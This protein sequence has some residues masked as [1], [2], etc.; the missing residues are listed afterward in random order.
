MA[1][2]KLL[3]NKKII[4]ATGK[5]EF[6]K[7]RKVKAEYPM[8]YL[9]MD[10]ESKSINYCKQVQFLCDG[11]TVPIYEL[12]IIKPRSNEE[13]RMFEKGVFGYFTDGK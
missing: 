6:V 8:Q 3:L 11:G 4:Q 2:E 9:P 1:E 12:E 10:R 5:R 7:V 13:L